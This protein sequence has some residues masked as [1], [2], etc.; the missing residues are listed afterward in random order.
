M[1]LSKHL[2]KATEAVRRRNWAFAVKLYAQLLAL[3]PDNGDA[4]AGLREALF[5]KA[6]SKPGSR[7]GALLGGGVHLLTAEIARMCKQ[8]GA[9]ARAY[10]RY[11]VFDP[12]NESANVR[13]GE[14]CERAGWRQSALAVFRAFATAQPRSL[15]ASKRAGALLHEAGQLDAALQFYEQALR[16]DPRDQDSIRARKNLAAEGALK[17]TGIETA[18]SS[19]ELMRDKDQ[20]R[21]IDQQNRLQLGKDE[22]DAELGQLEA[23]LA[24]KPGDRATLLRVAELREMNQDLAGALDCVERALQVQ[25]DGVA[26]A[27]AGD[28]RLRLQERHLQEAVARGDAGAAERIRG[29]LQE[30]RLAEYRRRTQQNPTDLGLRFQL[31]EA[32]LAA[33]KLDEAIAELQLAVKDPR[34]RAE[35]LLALARAFRGKELSDL[36]SSQLDKALEAAGSVPAL[37][38]E[39]LYEMGGLAVALGQRDVALKRFAQILEQDIGFKDVARRIEQLKSESR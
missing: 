18:Q 38:N 34:R 9:A 10:E 2:E 26:V 29:T 12:L 30:M 6:E 13:L 36:A 7:A 11:L 39:V 22:I 16:V 8:H 5:K 24:E 33:G 14:A 28:L 3:Q 37:R 23:R 20:H 31:G 1:D 17:K 35:S 19:R 27:K 21:K 32:L 15:V 25:S 4:R